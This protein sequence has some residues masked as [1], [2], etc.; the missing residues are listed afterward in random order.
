MSAA[1]PMQQ[2]RHEPFPIMDAD[3][4]LYTAKEPWLSPA[5]AFTT[6]K[7]AFVFRSRI[8]P[9]NG[10]QRFAQCGQTTAGTQTST[11]VVSPRRVE[12]ILD[13]Q[14]EWLCL[15]SVAFTYTDATN[16][17]LGYTVGLQS[18]GAYDPFSTGT[19]QYGLPVYESGTS[20]LIGIVKQRFT[21]V[22]SGT[23]LTAAARAD[24]DW[25]LH[26]DYT[27]GDGTLGTMTWEEDPRL[28]ITG[29]R[30]YRDRDGDS[31]LI[32]TNTK[33]LFVF[34]ETTK[35]FED[36]AGSDTFTGAASDLFW[37]WPAENDMLLTNGI[38]APYKYTG[39][40]STLATL[41]TTIGAGPDTVTAATLVVVFKNRLIYFGTTE[42]AGSNQFPRR[43]RWSSAGAYET[44]ATAD[45]VDAP[46][47]LG[48]VRTAQKIA[49]RLFVGFEAGWMELVF[50]GDA[51]SLFEF[52]ETTFVYGAVSKLGSVPDG[53]RI[54]AR[55]ETGIQAI[56]P[57]S[58]YAADESIPD[59]IVERMDEANAAF[60]I[61]A[62]SF[63]NRQFW[64][65]MVNQVTADDSPNE[66]LVGQY[67]EDNRLR[68]STYDLDFTAFN[69]YRAGSSPVWDDVDSNFDDY[70]SIW[71]AS[72]T[73]NSPI[74]I[75]ADS[76]GQFA[77][78]KGTQDLR[79]DVPNA[80]N[81]TDL[82]AEAGLQDI[83]FEI[84]TERLSPY[85]GMRSHFGWLDLYIEAAL[86]VTLTV[87]FRGDSRLA[88]Y[89]SVQIDISPTV[90]AEK[91]YRK[92]LVNKTA[93]FH[94]I[95]IK[96]S[97]ASEFAIDALI[98]WFR[99]AGRMRSF[100]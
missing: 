53:Q 69:A 87:E 86:G 82:R 39:S 15:E 33:R 18:F 3:V 94:R 97:G 60:T 84:A 45:Y 11:A 14:N 61:A 26:S 10:F 85:P 6:L 37:M 70:D 42:G 95:T 62:R 43:A 65:S 4:G 80:F 68:W 89:K 66:I 56:D 57:N 88:A 22:V 17:V 71:D 81:T 98:P 51:Q 30:S 34:N 73:A 8:R 5:N 64:F 99:P 83:P 19:D 23:P 2:T 54:L 20:T 76:S 44:L 40:S 48:P 41:T 16:G 59:Y 49:D 12:Y 32:A 13:D 78:T 31:Y 50:T 21:A 74:V 67:Q 36:Q 1:I 38:D 77:E 72:G 9:R 35:V 75:A 92:I 100:G 96:A 58:Q 28:P 91:I 24:I 52:E 29:M 79:N 7:D 25:G 27:T 93:T 63:E 90:S 46:T 55:T 47:E